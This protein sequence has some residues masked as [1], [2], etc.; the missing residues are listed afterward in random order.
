MMFSY[1]HMPFKDDEARRAYMRTYLAEWRAGRRR[2]D[3]V[4]APAARTVRARA[5]AEKKRKRL[6][7]LQNKEWCMQQQRERRRAAKTA[8][9]RG[10]LRGLP[11][12]S[13]KISRPSRRTR[14]KATTNLR[15][16]A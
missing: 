2:G 7:F 1:C 6:W 3:A 12:S 10:L 5:A 16:A 14:N 4:R 13:G 9:E 11:R 8:A 15:T